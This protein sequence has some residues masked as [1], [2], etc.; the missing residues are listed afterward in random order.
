MKNYILAVFALASIYLS[1]TFEREIETPAIAQET[2]IIPEESLLWVNQQNEAWADSL[3]YQ[4][5]ALRYEPQAPV[6]EVAKTAKTGKAK[7]AEARKKRREK[8]LKVNTARLAYLED[9]KLKLAAA[10]WLGTPYRSGRNTKRG[11]DCSGF[12]Q[13]IYKQVYGVSLSRSSRS[14][15]QEVQPIEADQ[16]RE[17]DLV[18]FKRKTG[19]IYHVGIYLKDGKFI[20]S[21]SSGGVMVNSLNQGYYSR[22]FYA[23]GR[24]EAN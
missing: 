16:L 22:N 4:H 18:F 6:A 23:A 19:P 11:T 15:F 9:E 13:K 1:F 21:A 8:K 10:Q 12:V 5:L 14:M 3:V 24:I 17:G 2:E 7:K 20:H